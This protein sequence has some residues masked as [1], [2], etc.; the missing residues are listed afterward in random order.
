MNWIVYTHILS[1]C[2][3]IGGSILLFGLGLFLKEPSAKSA[4]YNAIGPFYGYF[5]TLWL[6]ILVITGISLGKT[7]GLMAML[8]TD[9]PLAYLVE[10]KLALVA[11]LI[12]LTLIHLVI[13]FSTHGKS[14]TPM[15]H[16]LSRGSSMGIFILNL[17][18][19][20]VAGQIR[21]ML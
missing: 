1:A 7:Y 17:I 3:W 15:Q 4:V 11:T 16:W 20:E 13:A 12:L 18:I 8:W 14:R 2:A 10:I 9:S 19:L 5:E 6:V 21:D